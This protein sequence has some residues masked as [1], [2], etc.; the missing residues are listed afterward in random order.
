LELQ[1]GKV[2]CEFRVSTERKTPLNENSNLRGAVC[3]SL[4]SKNWF[5]ISIDIPLPKYLGNGM[6]VNADKLGVYDKNIFRAV[7]AES[8][9]LKCN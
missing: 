6:V 8:V 5:W 9:N 2:H 4:D 1:F 7:K 3:T